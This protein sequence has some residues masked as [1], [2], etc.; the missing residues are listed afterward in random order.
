LLSRLAVLVLVPAV[1][2]VIGCGIEEPAPEPPPEPVEVEAAPFGTPEDETAVAETQVEALEGTPFELNLN[3]PV[4]PDFRAAYQRRAIIVVGFFKPEA[5]FTQGERVNYPQGLTVDR[6]VSSALESLRPEYPGVEFFTYD[7]G[8][9]GPAAPAGGLR[10]GEYGSLAAQLNVGFTPFVAVLAP[11]AGG[12]HIENLWQGYVEAG[13]MD[14]ALFDV[15]TDESVRTN[16]SEFAVTLESVRLTSAGGGIEYFTVTNESAEDVNLRGWSLR[17]LDPELGE[18]G[19][20]SP[21]VQ[22]PDSIPIAPG[23]T[24]SVGRVPGITDERGDRVAGT[25][26]GGREMNLVAGDQVALVDPSGAVAGSA[27][28]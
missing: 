28:I 23:E 12:Y 26:R 24:V 16:T 14:Q 18:P 6:E 5:D 13:V 3:Q 22:I 2:L 4:P 7:I 15:T 19:E 17:V 20:D 27:V 1:L 11:R 9:P 8:R 10:S 25:F 21:G